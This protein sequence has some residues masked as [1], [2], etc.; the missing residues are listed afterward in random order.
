MMEHRS[1]FLVIG[2]LARPTDMAEKKRFRHVITGSADVSPEAS[3]ALAQM[4]K[5]HG[6][7][8]DMGVGPWEF[9]VEIERLIAV[10]AT[11]SDL[12]WLVLMGYVEHAREVTQ[13]DDSVRQFEPQAN[14]SLPERTCFILTE[15]GLSATKDDESESV[16]LS[17]VADRVTA[18]PANDCVPRWDPTTRVLCLG[19]RI[20]KC[21]RVP[22]QNQE[23]V[24]SAFEEEGWAPVIDDPLPPT[25]ETCPAMRLRDTVRRL[26]ANQAN[27]LLRFRGDG[28]GRRILWESVA[29]VTLPLGIVR[30]QLRRAA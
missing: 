25:F 19:D 22:A 20:V 3:L 7:A 2:E 13:P 17:L 21:Y 12:R 10:G 6:Y 26:N 29:E 4:A 23:T 8:C 30:P 27:H 28:T 9:A 18:S 1:S 11:T 15:A 14:L 16:I 5:A 24:L